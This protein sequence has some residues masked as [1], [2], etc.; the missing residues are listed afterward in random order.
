[1]RAEYWISTA[2]W[3]AEGRRANKFS[4]EAARKRNKFAKFRNPSRVLNLVSRSFD[5]SSK[6]GMDSKFYRAAALCA[7]SSILYPGV[8]R[9]IMV[10]PNPKIREARRGE[11]R[12]GRRRNHTLR[13]RAELIE[14]KEAQARI[15]RNG[16]RKTLRVGRE[17]GRPRWWRISPG[18]FQ[19]GPSQTH[20]NWLRGMNPFTF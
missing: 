16:C 8:A 9:Q 18:R 14:C 5:T 20:I 3:E 11:A 4:K 15:M 17:K 2:S 10:D 1:M 6:S 13:Q 19:N 7:T 12:R